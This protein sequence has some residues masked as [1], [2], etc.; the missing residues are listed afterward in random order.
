MLRFSDPKERPARDED[1]SDPAG[2]LIHDEVWDDFVWPPL[3]PLDP[4][5]PAND[6]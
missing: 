5:A 1:P 3:S 4:H 2:A 6:A